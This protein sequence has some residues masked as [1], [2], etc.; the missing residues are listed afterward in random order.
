M[1]TQTGVAASKVLILVGA[2]GLSSY[3]LPAAAIGAMGYCYM[4]WKSAKEHKV[5]ESK[6]AMFTSD[7]ENEKLTKTAA[8]KGAAVHRSIRF[9][10]G[11]EGLAL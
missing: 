8:V 4:W 9:S 10:F 5:V 6:P 2:G 1:A 3:I 11:K 7:V